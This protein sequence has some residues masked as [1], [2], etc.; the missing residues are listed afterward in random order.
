MTFAFWFSLSMLVYIYAGYPLLVWALARVFGREVRRADITPTVSLL[1]PA[2]NE[3]A[4][5][6]AKLENSLRL[7][8][9]DERLEIVVASDGSTDRTTA[10]AKQFQSRG[11]RVIALRAHVGKSDLL[12][13]TVPL[14]QGEV[15]VFSDASSELQPQALTSLVRP[16]ADPRVRSEE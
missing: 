9:P 15:V 7:D 16:F 3:E 12:S 11:I 13:R 1:I 14:L 8:Y 6:A 4:H 2:Y 10:L 5:I